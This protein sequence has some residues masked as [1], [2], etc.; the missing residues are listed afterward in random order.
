MEPYELTYFSRAYFNK[1]G[2]TI[3]ASATG[4]GIQQATVSLS[5]GPRFHFC[6][7]EAVHNSGHTILLRCNIYSPTI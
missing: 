7:N 4:F 1:T 6:F 3:L 2:G 5:S